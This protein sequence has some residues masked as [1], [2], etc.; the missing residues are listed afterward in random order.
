MEKAVRLFVLGV[1]LFAT[2]CSH[3]AVNDYSPS[4][5]HVSQLRN[6][7]KEPKVYIEEF[8]NSANVDERPTCRVGA[9]VSPAG[10]TGWAEYVRSALK[11]ELILAQRLT[12][13]PSS[14]GVVID[15]TLERASF[16]SNSGR[17]E[18][19]LRLDLSGSVN[20]RKRI[21]YKFETSFSGP[22]ACNG[23]AN[24]FPRA[25][26]KLIGN[27]ISEPEFKRALDI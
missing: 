8:Q 21:I 20:I 17:W 15:G 5:E 22:A 7:S 13:R 11:S 14:S 24:A 16:N 9:K 19:A 26:D 6:D 25:V 18:L 1:S 2:G 27:I 12:D 23:V 3:Y 4:A 10:Q